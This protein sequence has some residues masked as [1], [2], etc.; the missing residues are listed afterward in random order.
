MGSGVWGLGIGGDCGN[1]FDEGK[2]GLLGEVVKTVFAQQRGD[3]PS[4]PSSFFPHSC[5]PP[6]RP[7]LRLDLA[8]L[9]PEEVVLLQPEPELL[10]IHVDRLE[11]LVVVKQMPVAPDDGVVAL[12]PPIRQDRRLGRQAHLAGNRLDV[13]RRCT[14]DGR[15]TLLRHAEP[16][17][18]DVGAHPVGKGIR[19]HGRTRRRFTRKRNSSRS[20]SI[21]LSS[22]S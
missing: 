14:D 6:E 20:M 22:W 21:V 17:A 10:A 7:A 11:Q 4:L 19:R 9:A 18:P 12:P 1:V 2:A 3:L 8:E 16:V 13:L 15:Q 5:A